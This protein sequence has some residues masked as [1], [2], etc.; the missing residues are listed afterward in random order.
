MF[1]ADFAMEDCEQRREDPKIRHREKNTRL[2]CRASREV[3]Q[4]RGSSSPWLDASDRHAK[5]HGGHGAK[6]CQRAAVADA[7]DVNS[8]DVP[9]GVVWTGGGPS[10]ECGK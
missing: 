5:W 6:C 4:F 2:L 3:E 1:I 8:M 9:N 10:L 7:A